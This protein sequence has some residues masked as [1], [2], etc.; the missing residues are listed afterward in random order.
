HYVAARMEELASGHERVHMDANVRELGVGNLFT[1]EHYPREDQN[2]KYMIVAADYNVAGDGAGSDPYSCR[3]E[4]VPATE[5]FRVA[6]VTPRTRMPGPQ[7]AVVVGKSG[8]EI[9]VDE[10]GRVKVQ[11]MWDRTGKS[12]ENSSCWVRVAQI[13]AG[14]AFGGFQIPRIGEEV[15]VDF[16]GGEDRKSTR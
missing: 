10:Y 12:D 5:P 4:V 6:C 9:W 1:L 11:F 7:T 2:R 15:V 13:W 16:L 3:F 8:E 14:N